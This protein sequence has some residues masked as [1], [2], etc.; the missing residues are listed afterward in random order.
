MAENYYEILGV[1]VGAEKKEIKKA[2]FK[3][4]RTHSPEKDPEKFQQIRN[5]YENLMSDK[6]VSVQVPSHI[7]DNKLAKNMLNQI[8]A[9]MRAHDYEYAARTAEEAIRFFGEEETF[10]YYHGI[11][12]AYI[13]KTGNAIKSLEKLTAQY[14]DKMLYFRELAVTYMD[15]GFGKKAFATFE[16]AFEMG[17]RDDEFLRLFSLCCNERKQ[18]ARGTEV[19]FELVRKEDRNLRES[20]ADMLEAFTGLIMLNQNSEEKVLLEILTEFQKFEDKAAVYLDE[21]KDT[22]IEVAA[23]MVMLCSQQSETLQKE[24][25]NVLDKLKS[26]FPEKMIDSLINAVRLDAAKLKLNK[27]ERLSELMRRGYE[28]FLDAPILYEDDKQI[29]QFMRLDVELCMIEA[30]PSIREEINIIKQEYPEYY[31]K[32][33]DF[34]NRLEKGVNLNILKDRLLKDYNRLEKY[35]S[36]GTYYEKYP[37]KRS[38]AEEPKWDSLEEG[39]FVRQGAKVGRNDPC[40]CGSGKKYKHCCGRK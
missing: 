8:E 9:C 39:T 1:P 33:R 23:V 5:A 12:S 27:D 40:P 2:Y 21:Y 26:R 28:A 17:C 19:L 6:M 24:A 20:M 11:A 15:R 16:Q 22:V 10:L 31:D 4:V 37:E 32:I 38:G 36:G 35:I 18:N 3:L 29:A 34:I 13:G 30:W 14:P 25:E 7:P